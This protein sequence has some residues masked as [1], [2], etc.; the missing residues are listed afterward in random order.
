MCDKTLSSEN[1]CQEQPLLLKHLEA[2]LQHNHKKN[3]TSITEKDAGKVFHI[4]DSLAVLPEVEGAPPGQMADLGSGAG[5]P[6]IPLA[7]VSGR[8]TTLLESNKKKAQFLQGFLEENELLSRIGV[9]AARSEEA[10]LEQPDAFAAVTARAVASLP[11][12]LELAAPLLMLGG[13]F[14]ALKGKP[15]SAELEKAALAAEKLSM[16]LISTRAYTLNYKGEENQRLVLVYK[17]TAAPSIPL[18]RRPGMATKRPLS[19]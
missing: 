3:L 11:A 19:S 6:G 13:H 5:F 1:F 10:A 15:D 7:L 2:V 8:H 17:K 14:I 9:I 4:E 12:L 18:P 16:H